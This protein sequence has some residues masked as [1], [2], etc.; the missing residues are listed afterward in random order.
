MKYHRLT[1]LIVGLSTVSSQGATYV[2][3]FTGLGQGAALQG[4]DGWGQNSPNYNDGFEDYPLAFGT[5]IDETPA[6]AVG[7]YY[8]T[9]PPPGGRFY[10]YHSLSLSLMNTVSFSMR[11]GINDS[12]GFTVGENVY[13]NERNS[14]SIGFTD[15]ADS[16]LFSI[17]FDPVPGDPDP[18]FSP[19]D[20]WNVSWSSGGNQSIPVMAIYETQLH[21]LNLTLT[22]S[23]ADVNFNIS[24]TASNT[25]S[26]AGTLIGL[27]SAE[28]TQ[29]QIGIV[30]K[31][32][33]FGTNHLAFEG[34]TAAIPEPSSFVILGFAGVCL[35]L[36][37]RREAR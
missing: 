23:G 34:I 33:A 4:V 9:V 1:L 30:E 22:P 2:S 16:E 18:T 26:S 27:S 25:M 7:G 6:G 32:G 29:L 37:R 12:A 17:I 19:G 21:T 8:D 20:I 3:N 28:I 31:D 5:M 35:T 36:R 14:F 24:L 10:A 15:S 13:G 11:F